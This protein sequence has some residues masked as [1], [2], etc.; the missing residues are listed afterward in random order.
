MRKREA[1]SQNHP[2]VCSSFDGRKIYAAI[3]NARLLRGRFDLDQVA[4]VIR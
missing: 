1:S 2:P 4:A 3:L